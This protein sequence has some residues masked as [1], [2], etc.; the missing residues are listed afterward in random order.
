MRRLV[1]VLLIALAAIALAAC[2][3]D[4]PEPPVT[5][6]A[7]GTT[8]A[9]TAPTTAPTTAATT[10]PTS[11]ATSGFTSAPTSGATSG[12]TS[13]SASDACAALDDLQNAIAAPIPDFDQVKAA[14]QHVLDVAGTLSDQGQAALLG[15]IGQDAQDAAQAFLDGDFAKGAAL[16]NQVIQTIGPAR[17]ALGCT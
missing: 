16:T 2:G 3:N 4:L 15:S 6:T 10:A 8:A 11:A 12:A 1:P 5:P 7:A 14:A 17:V 9:T 13:G